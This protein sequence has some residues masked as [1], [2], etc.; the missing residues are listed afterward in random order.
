MTDLD[1][2]WGGLDDVLVN[3]EDMP[4]DEEAATYAVSESGDLGPSATQEHLG[5]NPHARQ[6]NLRIAARIDQSK[7]FYRITK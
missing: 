7:E 1:S 6:A 5:R 2:F 4:S 3:A